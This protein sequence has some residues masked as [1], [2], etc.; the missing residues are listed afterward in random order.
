MS[1]KNRWFRTEEVS[2]FVKVLS[3]YGGWKLL[4][5][6]LWRTAESKAAWQ[7]KLTGFGHFYAFLTNGILR[8]VGFSSSVDG[9][10]VNIDAHNGIWIAEHCMA[11]PAMVIFSFSLLLFRGRWADKA[12]FI[13]LGILFIFFLNLFRLVSL[14]ILMTK[15]PETTYQLY[16]RYVFFGITYGAILLMVVWWMDRVMKDTEEA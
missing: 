12:W 16:H 2:F 4:H 15:V 3:V 11:I 13:P 5:A 1:N 6:Y 10:V 8:L 14:S 7:A 9:A